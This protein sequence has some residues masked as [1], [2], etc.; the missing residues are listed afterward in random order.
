MAAESSPTVEEYLEVIFRLEQ[1]AGSAKTKEL[2]SRLK[3]TPGTITNTAVNL[4]KRGLVQRDRYKGLRLTKKGSVMALSVL[5]KHRLSERLLTDVLNIAWDK[6]HDLACKFEHALTDEVAE[7]IEKVLKK[8]KTCPHG[9]PIPTTKGEIVEAQS[10]PLTNLRPHDK[11]TI[12]RITHERG[13]IL[14][15][16]TTLGLVPGVSVSVEERAPFNGPIIVKALGTSYALGPSIA[17]I[18]S[19]R[20]PKK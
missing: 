19:V 9:N 3:V 6:V 16:L 18:I 12:T 15:Y 1:S 2:A 14:H 4:E 17:S 7:S 11:G 8:P 20:R 10:E 13:D 5:R